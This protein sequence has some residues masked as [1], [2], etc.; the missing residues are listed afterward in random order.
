M[1][2]EVELIGFDDDD[3]D[4]EIGAVRRRMRRMR[5][6]ARRVVVRR[7]RT[8]GSKISPASGRKRVLPLGSV[9]VAAGGTGSL[10]VTC[11]KAIQP[12][13]LILAA[14]GPS[15]GSVRVTGILIGVENQASGTGVMPIEAFAADSL[16]GL[17]F[18]PIP[19]GQQVT[20]QLSNTDATTAANV[21]GLFAGVAGD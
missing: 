8:V 7:A 11:L 16:V 18:N 9:S 1:A 17:E 2:D 19:T 6:P 21:S 12:S 4:D 14:A 3:D 20:I 5:R 10:T 15:A 13:R